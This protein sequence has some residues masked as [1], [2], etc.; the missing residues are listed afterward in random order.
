MLRFCFG[1]TYTYSTYAILP[2][3]DAVAACRRNE[4]LFRT[5]LKTQR[6]EFQMLYND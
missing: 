4:M 2:I 3:A 6:F 5:F 1:F